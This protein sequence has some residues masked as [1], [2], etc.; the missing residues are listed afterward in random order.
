MNTLNI[1]RKMSNIISLIVGG[2]VD[3][4]AHEKLGEHKIAEL[5]KAMGDDCG[6]T[7]VDKEFLQI[8][9]DV[10]GK[11][12]IDQMKKQDVESYLDL[13]RTFESTKRSLQMNKRSKV[14][15]TIPFVTLDELCKEHHK[16]DFS[17]KLSE[18]KYNGNISLFKDRLCIDL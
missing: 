18:S 11:D 8:F 9:Y 1:V 10:V 16:K 4:T 14:N 3:I 17:T 12:L 6:G 15:I 2:T 7:S 13:C 5:C